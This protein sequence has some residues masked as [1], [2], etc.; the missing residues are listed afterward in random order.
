MVYNLVFCC[1]SFR[2]NCVV[3]TQTF[4]KFYAFDAAS[5]SPT[6]VLNQ[7]AKAKEEFVSLPNSQRK[8]LQRLYTQGG[9]VHGSVRNL[10]VHFVTTLK[11]GSNYSIEL[12]S[13][14]MTGETIFAFKDFLH[15]TYSGNT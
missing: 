12:Q 13:S 10:L 8:K 6:L 9:A 2:K 14:S 11:S 1:Q 7:N 3:K 4:M 5:V 15:K